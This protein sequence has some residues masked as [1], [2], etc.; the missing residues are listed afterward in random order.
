MAGYNL[1]YKFG[2]NFE[3]EM[4]SAAVSVPAMVVNE[5]IRNS[6]PPVYLADGDT[7]VSFTIPANSIIKNFYLVVEEAMTGTVAVALND[8]SATE[9]LPATAI[10]AVGITK[11]ALVDVYTTTPYDLIFTFA[12]DQS[13]TPDGALKLAFDYIQLDTNTAKYINK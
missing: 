12:G 7:V 11:S 9:V 4:S 5:G 13:T 6:T 10:T 8:G 2:N 1:T 3:N